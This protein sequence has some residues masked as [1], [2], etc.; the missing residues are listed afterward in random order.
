MAKEVLG[1][2][3][4]VRFAE[5]VLERIDEVAGGNRRARFI[6]SAVD[7]ALLRGKSGYDLVSEVPAGGA[8]VVEREAPV[9]LRVPDFVQAPA[10]VKPKGVRLVDGLTNAEFKARDIQTLRDLVAKG[11]ISVSSACVE[12]GWME[13]RVLRAAT[14]GGISM[15][16]GRLGAY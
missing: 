3:T 15:R 14:D 1:P 4:V 9:R 7:A 6:R 10:K 11:P 12:L 8:P 13:L 2:A 5:G 16:D